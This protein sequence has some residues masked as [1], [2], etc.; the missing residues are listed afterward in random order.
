[1][2]LGTRFSV[3][4]TGLVL[5]FREFCAWLGG[6]VTESVGVLGG[7]GVGILVNVEG[8]DGEAVDVGD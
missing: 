6:I 3:C 1:M 5:G 2:L 8:V 4:G 7:F